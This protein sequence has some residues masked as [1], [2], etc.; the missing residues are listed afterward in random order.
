VNL[1]FRRAGRGAN[2]TLSAAQIAAMYR[3]REVSFDASSFEPP[4]ILRIDGAVLRMA[5]KQP[6]RL[7]RKLELSP[8]VPC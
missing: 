7:A 1:H 8:L 3:G 4:R 5:R 6:L 2:H